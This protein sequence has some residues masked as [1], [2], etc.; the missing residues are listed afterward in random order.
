MLKQFNYTN[1]IF[2]TPAST[3]YYEAW[4]NFESSDSQQTFTFTFTLHLKLLEFT[5]VFSEANLVTFYSIFSEWK[6]SILS[7]TVLKA[8]L[9]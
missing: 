4:L 9:D 6:L 2:S 8:K 5:S 7:Q 3:H 1:Y